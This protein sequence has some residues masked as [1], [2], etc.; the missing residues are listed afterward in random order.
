M[1]G[2]R[3][4]RK[5]AS[6]PRNVSHVEALDGVTGGGAGVVQ[7]EVLC[8]QRAAG[9]RSTVR[10][11][12]ASGRL[13]QHSAPARLALQRYAWPEVKAAVDAGVI[14][15]D[16]DGIRAAYHSLNGMSM[17]DMVDSIRRCGKAGMD[18]LEAEL[19]N[20]HG[21]YDWPRIHSAIKLARANASGSVAQSAQAVSYYL[22]RDDFAGAGTHLAKLGEDN[23]KTVLK[24]LAPA[25]CTKLAGGIADVGSD[26]VITKIQKALVDVGY[27]IPARPD[28][29][30]DPGAALIDDSEHPFRDDPECI[31]N[32]TS[33]HYDT[34]GREFWINHADGSLITLSL[35]KVLTDA[36]PHNQGP[37]SR[38]GA[39]VSQADFA[40]GSSAR[41]IKNLNFTYYY[42]AKDGKI[43]PSVFTRATAPNIVAA[44]REIEEALPQAAAM[45]QLGLDMLEAQAT[46]LE[47]ALAGKVVG[48]GARV[49]RAAWRARGGPQGGRGGGRT[50]PPAAA[51]TDAEAFTRARAA[52]NAAVQ[53]Y[54]ELPKSARQ[55]IATVTAGVNIE[56]GQSAS[57]HN[58]AGKCA[59]DVVVERLGGD[60]SKVRFSEAVRPRTG[61]QVPVC[62]RCQG[63]YTPDQFP[64]GA[65]FKGK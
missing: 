12:A 64:E 6:P 22:N 36:G 54:A 24:H 33:A 23:L 63:K 8:F 45:Q 57:G 18:A 46:S 13:A 59:E 56:T 62:E 5:G 7:A 30:I 25:L 55:E 31:D 10:W 11:L 43:W 48:G 19:E 34:I 53:Q 49:G 9:N 61:E 17:E 3:T 32:I 1:A 44:A 2:Q 26:S 51:V 29:E 15:D 40:D 65:I 50:A 58:S 37:G 38:G 35:N 47:G 14:V 52:R 28:A 27:T 41:L 21:K 16:R 4:E 60:P 42:R 39:P 20:A